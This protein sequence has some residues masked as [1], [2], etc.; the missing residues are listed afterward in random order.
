MP[1]SFSKC[2]CFVSRGLSSM[3]FQQ[4]ELYYTSSPHVAVFP[5][6]SSRGG[7]LDKFEWQ[8]FTD[9]CACAWLAVLLGC[10]SLWCN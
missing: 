8:Q 1:N 3:S 2:A 4:F 6:T 10:D 7:L 5:Y 9:A